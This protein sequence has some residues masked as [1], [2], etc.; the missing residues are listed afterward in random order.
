MKAGN[1]TRI[2]LKRFSDL[3]R[4]FTGRCQDQ[5][6]RRGLT[7]VDARQDRQCKRCGF[8]GTGLGLA[9]V[10]HILA[11]H[12]ANIRVEDNKPC[13]A[14]FTVEVPAA[15]SEE[16]KTVLSGAALIS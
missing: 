15:L 16:Q 2:G 14:R 5:G 9:I 1:M 6:L 3:N 13:G 7:D 12:D 10:S 11:E 4:E 8:T